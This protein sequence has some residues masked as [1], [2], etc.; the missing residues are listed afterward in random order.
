MVALVLAAG[1]AGAARGADRPTRYSLAN[2]CWSLA[3]SAGH[4]VA[5]AER[6]RLQATDLGSY[7]LYTP[8]SA[9]VAAAG[10]GSVG[11]VA[12]P[13]PAADW[14]VRDGGPGTFT[15]SPKSAPD[16]LLV[17]SGSGSLGLGHAGPTAQFTFVPADGCAVYPEAELNATGTPFTGQTPFGAVKGWMDGH[18]HWMNFELLGGNFK[19]GRPWDPYGI[20]YALPDCSSV[21]GPQGSAAPIQNFLDYGSPVSPHDTTGWPTLASWSRATIGNSHEG[22]YWRWMQRVWM[23]GMRLMVMP[24][25]DN[26]VLCTLYAGHSHPCDEM[27]TVTRALDDMKQ[28]QDYVD[29]QAGGPG[30]GFFQIVHDPFEARRVI[31]AGKL[32]V[33]EEIEISE[34]FN[35]QGYD[36]QVSNCTRADIDRG[37]QS[38]YD[39][40][41]R[42]MLLL[43][44]FDNPLTGVRFDGGPIGVLINA[45]NRQSSGSYWSAQTCQ[46]PLHDNTIETGSPEASALANTLTQ[47]LGVGGGTLPS[48][49][50]GP[51]CNTR[52]L[53]DLGGYLVRRMID[54]GM[55]VNP[56]HMSQK[57]VDQTL[58]IAESRHY[59]GVISPHGWMDPGNW[60]RIWKLGGMVRYAGGGVP[61]YVKSWKQYR[62]L[63]SP[64]AIGSML[65]TDIAGLF[66][67]P[68]PSDDAAKRMS[69]PFKSLDGKVTFDRQRT[70]QRTFDYRTEGIA[71]YGLYADWLEDLRLHADPQLIRDVMSSSEAY[72]E[73]WERAEGVPGPR[74][75]PGD[76]TFTAGGMRAIR[77]RL[78]ADAL[79]RAAGQPQRRTRGWSWC[80][81]GKGTSGPAVTAVLSPSG[82]V[83]LVATTAPGHDAA[84]I[85][86]GASASVLR[87]RARPAGGGRWL[88]RAGRA[89][90]V[91]RVHSGRVQTVAVATRSIAASRKRLSSYLR[92]VRLR[93]ARPAPL[94]LAPTA[95]TRASAANVPPAVLGLTPRQAAGLV[96]LCSLVHG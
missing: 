83:G 60:P 46:G 93:V 2:G 87:G 8:G 81:R 57:A 34:L 19:C 39:R 52:G 73:M 94:V 68:A 82:M 89:T 91:Y 13:S 48:Y 1:T 45:G 28:L 58:T 16:Q 72:L 66:A 85:S 84:G 70:G 12:Q 64:Y 11:P 27:A 63:S 50:P 20:P 54:K 35:C 96:L 59:S 25:N 76:A 3:D 24:V 65:G 92:A 38:V 71:H 67:Q 10:D 32:A 23:S 79:L 18:L 95:A 69:Y 74:C 80:V 21:E 6:L 51:H 90:F 36:D 88:R 53:T 33:V 41:V 61:D 14:V 86:P 26:R 42:S 77:L 17:A 9:F 7:L 49:P 47:T 15:L 56:D 55:I 78:G 29:A 30:K 22:S 44:K 5:G 43:N 62:P 75:L 37:L 31:N 40:G 4:A